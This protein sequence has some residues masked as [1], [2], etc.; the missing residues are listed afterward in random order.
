MSK[1][2]TIA[3]VY[4]KRYSFYPPDYLD[5]GLGGAESTLVLLAK[6]LAK[7]GHNIEVYNCCFKDG[8]YDG[9]VWKS[10]WKL[11]QNKRF[12]VVISLRLLE[13]FKNYKFDLPIKAVWIHDEALEGSSK[14]DKSG[15]V[16]LWMSVS[17]T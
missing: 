4:S 14:L 5:R 11:D 8:T 15:D 10:L 3:F 12:D 1:R 2:L 6:A 17:N 13:T 7:L 9:V 16:K